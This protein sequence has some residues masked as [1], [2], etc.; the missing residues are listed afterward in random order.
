MVERALSNNILTTRSLLGFIM[1][2]LLPPLLFFGLGLIE[3]KFLEGLWAAAVMLPYSAFVTLIFGLPA[4]LLLNMIKFVK[5]RWYILAGLIAGI[6]FATYFILL[7][8]LREEIVLGGKTYFA[9]LVILAA[10]GMLSST[11]YWLTARP[12]QSS[13]SLTVK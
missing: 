1:A 4:V 12:D 2:G 8:L 13:T 6:G 3:G 7:G 9:Q 10:L 5:L 11:G